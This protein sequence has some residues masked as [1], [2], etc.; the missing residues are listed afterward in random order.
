MPN[1]TPP[2]IEYVQVLLVDCAI[3]LIAMSMKT[4]YVALSTRT[5]S[6]T[7]SSPDND[8]RF[9]PSFGNSYSRENKYPPWYD[10]YLTLTDTTTLSM[11]SIC[12]YPSRLRAA[13]T[14][15]FPLASGN[16]SPW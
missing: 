9:S 7:I 2:E 13:D 8:T 4:W 12:T 16:Q 14:S 3:F 1:P 11:P 10:G 6:A 5:P 15:I